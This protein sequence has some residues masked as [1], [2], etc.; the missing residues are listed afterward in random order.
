MAAD[1]LKTRDFGKK[2]IVIGLFV[3]IIFFG[4]FVLA[5]S[6]F[7]VRV[8]RQP[9]A[10]SLHMPW[11]KHMFALFGMSML[12]LIRSIFRVVEFLQGYNGPIF[13]S[14]AY[15]YIFDALLMLFVMVIVN[16][17]HPS[18]IRSLLRGGLAA[19]G[20]FRMV[21]MRKGD[22]RPDGVLD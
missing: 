22:E 17:F 18:E 16:W 8:V 2:I 20:V 6:L 7:Y 12:I 9:T 21:D 3:Q 11:R 14:E 19:V 4:I 10:R 5:S 13:Q 1:S 15:L